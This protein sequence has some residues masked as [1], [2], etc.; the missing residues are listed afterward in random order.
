[1]KIIWTKTA[2]DRLA[3]I[4]DYIKSDS[5]LNAQKW[6]ESVLDKISKLSDLPKIGR[7]VPEVNSESIREIIFGNYRIIYK[8]AN[9][10]IELATVRH[11]KQL[12]PIDEIL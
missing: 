6:V 8:I 2:A 1:M 5:P 3:E 12:L 9:E 11:F 10:N 7:K 4:H